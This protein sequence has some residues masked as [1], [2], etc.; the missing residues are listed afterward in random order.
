MPQGSTLV[1]NTVNSSGIQSQQHLD[2]AG[3]LRAAVALDS[4]S[5]SASM[6]LDSLG[7]LR[8]SATP[9]KSTLNIT[10]ATAVKAAPGR[11]GS[12]S[13][14]VAGSGEGGL[15]DHATTSGVAA[16]NQISTILNTEGVYK[17]DFSAAVG[18]VVVP[19]T[20]QTVAISWE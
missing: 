14:L 11:I 20:G 19:G 4:A 12:I 18:I 3:N 6:N 15:Y 16:A 7:N 2:A 5:A 13:V 9:A 1:S 8:S 17:I 10:S